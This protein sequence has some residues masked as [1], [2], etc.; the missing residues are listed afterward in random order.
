LCNT[1][2][3]NRGVVEKITESKT[4]ESPRWDLFWPLEYGGLFPRKRR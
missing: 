2:V 3:C 1:M 4:T